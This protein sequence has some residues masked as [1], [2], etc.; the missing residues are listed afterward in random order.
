MHVTSPPTHK[1]AI[2][3]G[4]TRQRIHQLKQRRGISIQDFL[5]PDFIFASLLEGNE[6]KLRYR[7][8]DPAVRAAIRK[9]LNS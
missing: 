5:D 3:Y 2:L 8:I 1:V 7:L 6:S 9:S 4:I